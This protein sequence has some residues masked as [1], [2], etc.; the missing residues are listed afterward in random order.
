MRLPITVKEGKTY[1]N[2][3]HTRRHV[4]PHLKACTM[5]FRPMSTSCQIPCPNGGTC[6]HVGK[7]RYRCL[8]LPSYTG[9]ACETLLPCLNTECK[10]GGS[11]VADDDICYCKCTRRFIGKSCELRVMNTHLLT[12]LL[13]YQAMSCGNDVSDVLL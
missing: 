5:K 11:Q 4:Q 1:T 10:N 3:P 8:C 9:E 13:Q 12:V 7:N 2:L 6:E